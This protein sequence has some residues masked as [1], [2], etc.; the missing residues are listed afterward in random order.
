MSK[1][2]AYLLATALVLSLAFPT[3]IG[4][5]LVAAS[6]RIQTDQSGSVE[7]PMLLGGRLPAVEVKINGQGPFLFAIDTGA[8][9]QLALTSSRIV[10]RLNLK[11]SGQMS[12]GDPSGKNA[13][14]ADIFQVDSVAIG[15]VRF[16]NLRATRFDLPKRTGET[17]PSAKI[18][19]ILGFPLFS[20]YL[21]TLDYV[22]G[23]VRLERGSL[24]APDGAEILSFNIVQGLP[25]L[26][27]DV[28]GTKMK[29]HIDSGNIRGAIGLPSAMIDQLPLAAEPTVAGKARTVN[30]EF[31]LKAAPLKGS[32]KIGKH[33]FPQPRIIFTEMTRSTANIGDGIL[34]QFAVTFDQKN[35][36]VRFVRKA[37]AEP[38]TTVKVAELPMLFRG[39]MPAVEVK[40]NGKGPFL[41]A[42]DTGAG[43]AGRI[44]SSL[45]EKLSLPEVGE[46]RGSDGSG[47]NALTMKVIQVDS[48]SVGGLEFHNLHLPSR[49]YNTSP[50]LPH[51]DGILGF[52]LFA[53]Y[54]LTLD[55]AAKRVRIEQ[56]QLPA[57]DGAEVLSFESQNGIPVVEL[58][59][60]ETKLRTHIDSGNTVGAFML[61]ASLAEKLDFVSPPVTVGK[62]RT[63]SSE[64]EIKRGQLK[65]SIWLGRFEFRDPSVSYPAVSQDG[66]MGSPA[67]QDFSLTFDQK[68]HRVKLAKQEMPKATVPATASGPGNATQFQQYAGR[69]GQRTIFFEDDALFIQRAGGPKLK[70]K[71]ASEGEFTLEEVPAAR[72]KF[73]KKDNAVELQ[74]RNPQGQWETAKKESGQ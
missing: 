69:Y 41:F 65:G 11:S 6:A 58:Q 61:P 42:I 27:I 5:G 12:V 37:A 34:R 19:G 3:S 13:L 39:P 47:A 43:G 59:V 64:I 20:D 24:P 50:N 33:E 49:N 55:Y 35:R 70:L 66:N 32:L 45:V 36:R 9:I 51:I 71:P 57:P 15:E 21:L 30:N 73:V 44:D 4:R 2:K 68:N 7:V 53:D 10:E 26:E 14:T 54:L 17:D 8:A 22:A 60:G 25:Q 48:L 40:V 18:D 67:L 62:A 31:E 72:I 38:I 52:N 63:V 1:I 56:G 74:V 29:A 16:S 28:A 23:R 46:A